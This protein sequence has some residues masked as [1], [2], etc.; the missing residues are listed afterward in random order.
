MMRIVL[1]ALAMFSIEILIHIYASRSERSKNKN[2]IVISGLLS[3][4]FD[5]LI[6]PRPEGPLRWPIPNFIY[7]V[8]APFLPVSLSFSLLSCAGS[9]RA[10][11][12]HRW[13]VSLFCVLLA[14]LYSWKGWGTTRSSTAWGGDRAGRP[15]NADTVNLASSSPSN[16]LIR[17]P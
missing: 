6:P 5:L 15:A 11:I 4:P 2:S 13:R 7:L 8:C 14:C 12:E 17:I 9:S 10:G 16:L 1:L 3:S